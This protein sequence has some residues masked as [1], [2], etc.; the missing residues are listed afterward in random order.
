MIET[1]YAETYHYEKRYKYPHMKPE[2][3]AIWERFIEAYPDAYE[4]CQY[5]VMVGSDPE[6]IDELD[7]QVGGDSW[8]LYQKKIDVLGMRDGA[9]DII[10]LKPRAGA[11]AVGQVKMYKKMFMKDYKPTVEPKMVIITNEASLDF[12][13]FARDE[14]VLV[15]VV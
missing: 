15:T 2:D 10:E 5:D 14:G 13:E 1:P 6:F 9:A 7:A 4:R 11:A 12:R 3:V 8:K